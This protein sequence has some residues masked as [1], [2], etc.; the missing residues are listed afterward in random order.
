MNETLQILLQKLSPDYIIVVL[1][2]YGAWKLISRGLVIFTEHG[3]K[4]TSGIQ[5]ISG[6]IKGIRS[7]LS[8]V[9][10]KLEDHDNRITRL[11]VKD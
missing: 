4:L 2:L 10:H 3:G 8:S 7:D 5:E 11:E 6:D 1:V 9:V